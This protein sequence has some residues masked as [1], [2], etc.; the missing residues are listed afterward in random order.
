MIYNRD[1]YVHNRNFYRRA[2]A[3]YSVCVRV[4]H[5]LITFYSSCGKCGT[6][7]YIRALPEKESFSYAKFLVKYNGKTFSSM[8]HEGNKM[9]CDN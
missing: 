3:L 7:H 2:L 5:I 8:Y 4:E 6:K 9:T 1:K